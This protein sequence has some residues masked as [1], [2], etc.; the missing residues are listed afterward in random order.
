MNPMVQTF[1]PN[2]HLHWRGRLMNIPWLFT[3]HHHF[4]L[5][6]N[7]TGIRFEQTEHFSG[8][9]ALVMHWIGSD[10]YENT[11][12]GFNSMNDALKERAERKG[13]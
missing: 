10:V 13:A 5:H 1:V 12:R 7:E 9:L 2:D 3:G 11:R 6:P 8:F 4:I